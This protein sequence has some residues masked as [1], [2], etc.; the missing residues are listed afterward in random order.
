MLMIPVQRKQENVVNWDYDGDDGDDY[1]NGDD[2]D[3]D[4]KT[5]PVQRK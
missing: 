2:D 4:D 3:G 1:D 5:I